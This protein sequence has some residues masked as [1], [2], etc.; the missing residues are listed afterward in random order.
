MMLRKGASTACMLYIISSMAVADISPKDNLFDKTTLS[1]SGLFDGFDEEVGGTLSKN[2]TQIVARAHQLRHHPPRRPRPPSG[3]P[4]RRPRPDRRPRPN[5]PPSRPASTTNNRPPDRNSSPC[6]SHDMYDSIDSD[7]AAIKD[8]MN[9][10]R[11]RAHFL[12]GIVRL[13]AHDFLDFDR[14]AR[15]R[16]GPDGC[17]D[18]NHS[19]N[20]GLETIWC[21]DCVLRRLYV[22]KYSR[23]SR[24]DFWIAAAN[25]VI[26]Q[27]SIDGAL[28]L[29]DTFSWGRRDRDHCRGSGERLPEASGC[30]EVEEVFLRNMGLDWG[31]AVALLGAHT[32]GRGD[33]RFSGH[34]G[35]WVGSDKEAEVFDNQYYKELFTNAW[36][37]R[38][39]GGA[40]QDWTTGRGHDNERV[41]LNTDM[42]L[43]YDTENSSPCCS[44]TD[45]F[46]ENGQSRC[47][48]NADR[49][50]SVIGSDHPRWEAAQAVR[51]FLG[52]SSANDNNWHFYEAFTLA[53]FK[54]T[55]NGR[56][57][58]KP[59][60]NEC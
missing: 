12:G 42:C 36:R 56:T 50:C 9:D 51:K 46:K 31:E 35:T 54:A 48:A 26:R 16:M 59:I 57:H 1:S 14:R 6:V 52:G 43:F 49:Q 27:T 3:R 5:R 38:K 10:S 34:G 40:R 25:A 22:N 29:R 21:R 23:I 47:E 11:D 55:L 44:R 37:P 18:P 58:L 33:N 15:D 2:T 28:D 45:L 60:M 13:A 24:A 17:F 32:L 8:S 39:M 4:P 30:D 19:S 41:M 20:G 53:W 7:I